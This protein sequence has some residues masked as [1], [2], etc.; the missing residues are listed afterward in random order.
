MAKERA[1]AICGLRRKDVL[2]PARLF[3]DLFFVVHVKSLREQTFRQAVATDH[4]LRALAAFFREDNHVVAV[5][6]V[7]VGRTESDMATV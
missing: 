1:D 3:G 5:A 7:F 6:G 2:E 4:V